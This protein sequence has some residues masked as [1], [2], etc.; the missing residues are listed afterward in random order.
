ML[1][2]TLKHVASS[3]RSYTPS[4]SRVFQCALYSTKVSK[5]LRVLFCGSDG[6]SSAALRVLHDEQRRDPQ[7][8]ASIDVLC[9]PGKRTG[10]GLKI[11][12][13]VP[14]K[15]VAQELGLRVHERDTFTGWQLP[16]PD[17]EAINLVIAVSFGL[18]V[19]PRILKST[20]YGGLNLHPSLLPAFPGAAP[21]QRTLLAGVQST[22]VSLQTLDEKAFDRG[23]ILA[24]TGKL[25]IEENSRYEDVLEM[26]TP[27]AADLLREGI[28]KKVYVPPLEA[29][30]AVDIPAEVKQMSAPKITSEDRHIDWERSADVLARYH[31]VLGALWVE[32]AYPLQEPKRWIFGDV[33]ECSEGTINEAKTRSVAEDTSLEKSEKEKLPSTISFLETS[34]I[35]YVDGGEGAIIFKTGDGRG[36]KVRQITVAG[37]KKRSAAV[38]VDELRRL[39]KQNPI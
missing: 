35:E 13:E 39:W 1:P 27:K 6:F 32:V 17:G 3:L 16:R 30:K 18:F 14:I 11:F 21:I 29:V 9:R 31:R 36:V 5:P 28:R 2:V 22:G 23:I 20:E 19:P 12:R 34:H 24:T 15:A 10:R 7:S 25:T 26:L 8:I 38:V 33:E 4:R 37:Q